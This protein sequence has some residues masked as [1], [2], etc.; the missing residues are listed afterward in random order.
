MR[1][2]DR[3]VIIVDTSIVGSFVLPDEAESLA[4]DAVNRLFNSPLIVPHHWRLEVANMLRTAV[5]RQRIDLPQRAAILGRLQGLDVIVD[6]PGQERAWT[7][8]L[9]LSDRFGLT[10][11]DAAYLELAQR[12]GASLA[13]LDRRLA[14]AGADLTIP[15]VTLD[16]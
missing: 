4:A 1:G 6:W 3:G 13:T 16:P 11:Y 8:V 12:H 15:L 9:A 2:G 14:S 10:P 5:R 7:S